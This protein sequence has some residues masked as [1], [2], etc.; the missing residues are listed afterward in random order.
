[1]HEWLVFLGIIV[2]LAGLGA[3]FYY[4]T[5]SIYGIE[6]SRNYPYRDL[7]VVLVLGGMIYMAIGA[8]Y[9][10]KK[11]GVTQGVPQGNSLF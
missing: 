5:I 3:Y 1:M 8:V 4:E 2:L 10:P 9:S 11:Q 6:I 7:G